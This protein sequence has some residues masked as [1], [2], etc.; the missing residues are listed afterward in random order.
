VIHKP[1]E[2]EGLLRA[3]EGVQHHAL[4]TG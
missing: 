4:A 3:I 2:F 1:F